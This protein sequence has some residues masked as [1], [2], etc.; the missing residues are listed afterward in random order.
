MIGVRVRIRIRTGIR[1]RIRIGIKIR[2][3]IRTGIGI[4][5]R[6]R[7]VFGFEPLQARCTKALK[8]ALCAPYIDTRLKEPCSFTKG[9]FSDKLMGE[10]RRPRCRWEDNIKMD[11][12]EVRCGDMDW[13]VMA[14][15]RDKG[16]T[17]VNAVMNLR[18]P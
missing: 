17:L 15:D 18:V 8:H 13:I 7:I 3:R 4:G 9:T 11:L 5:I 14:Q 6:I 10:L 2:I 16:R 1:I 12:Q